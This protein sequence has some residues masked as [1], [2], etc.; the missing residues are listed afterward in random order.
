MTKNYAYCTPYL[1]KHTSFYCVCV[2]FFSFFFKLLFLKVKMMKSPDA[3]FL[4]SKFQFSW[5]LGWGVIVCIT[6]HLLGDGRADTFFRM[7][8]Y[9]GGTQKNLGFWVGIGTLSWVSFSQVRLEKSLYKKKVNTNLEQKKRKKKK[10]AIVS[11][12]ISHFWSCTLTNLGQSV[13]V[14]VY[15]PPTHKYFFCGGSK[16]YFR[17][18]QPGDRNISNF[19]GAFCIG[20]S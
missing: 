14:M 18:L 10:I 19:L 17:I 5:W 20:G 8:V 9:I 3:F 11:S 6:P 2:F 4:F 12:T 15:N 16:F 7:Y 13:F 1:S